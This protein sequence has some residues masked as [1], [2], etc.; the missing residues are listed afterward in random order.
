MDAS[1]YLFPDGC[2][3][4]RGGFVTEFGVGGSDIQGGIIEGAETD[5]E[6]WGDA[7]GRVEAE[8]HISAP[9][10]AT[11]SIGGDISCDTLEDGGTCAVTPGE[12][13]D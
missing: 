13:S 4:S 8:I 5:V 7:V 1:R 10:D 2:P 6:Y 3:T 9:F 11:F 12:A